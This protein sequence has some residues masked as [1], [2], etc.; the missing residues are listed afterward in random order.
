[1]LWTTGTRTVVRI[2][3]DST[4]DIPAEI[5]GQLGIVVVPLHIQI[6]SEAYRDG[7]GLAADRVYRELVQGQ[8]VPKTSAPSPGDFVK[9]YRELAEETDS[10]ISIHL[11]P[12]YSGT[13]E[14]ASLAAGYVKDKC[15]VEVVD[16][17]TVSVGLG[18]IVVAAARAAREGKDMDEILDIIRDVVSRTR[19]FGKVDDFV[20]LLRGKRFRLSGGMVFLGRMSMAL[21]VKMLGEV[22]GG[23]RLRSPSL[24]IGRRMAV[25]DLRRRAGSFPAVKE[26]AIA[27]ST[28]PGEAEMLARS[29][30]PL[31][32][33]EHIMVTRLG[34]VSSTYVG[35]GT[36]V[37]ALVY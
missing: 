7:M 9:V 19:L 33:G 25:A 27:Y 20:Y 1:M 2:V 21:G 37:M 12:G 26:V 18:M 30:K 10:I 24:V 15:R 17:N 6:G 28:A 14:A 31:V 5:A 34:C 11:S 35:P 8:R 3:T 29:V 4:G 13:F 22:Y 36:L 16:S 32:G 23:G